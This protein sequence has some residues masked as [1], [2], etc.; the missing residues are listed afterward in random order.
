MIDN[1]TELYNTGSEINT[2]NCWERSMK[3]YNQ[4]DESKWHMR[5]RHGIVNFTLEIYFKY[6]KL[7]ASKLM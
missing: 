1:N 3:T 2:L 4:G 6:H 7:H 5:V